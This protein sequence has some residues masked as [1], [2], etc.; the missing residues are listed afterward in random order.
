MRNP[1]ESCTQSAITH[2]KDIKIH[3]GPRK[4][5]SILIVQLKMEKISFKKCFCFKKV[6]SFDL[7]EFS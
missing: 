6:L 1:G 4:A 7:P 2:K 3:R 5:A